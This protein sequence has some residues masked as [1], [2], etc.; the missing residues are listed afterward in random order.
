MML[1]IVQWHT[2]EQSYIQVHT[3]WHSRSRAAQKHQTELL[4]DGTPAV[5]SR[6]ILTAYTRDAI[7]DLLNTH[8]RNT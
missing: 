6:I 5:S 7:C 3:V 8:G 4:R 1:Y 2:R